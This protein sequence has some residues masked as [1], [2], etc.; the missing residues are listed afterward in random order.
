M[1]GQI[2]TNSTFGSTNF[3]GGISCILSANPEAGFSVASYNGNNTIGHGLG[4]IPEVIIGKLRTSSNWTTY[5]N[6]VDGSSDY[7]LLNST[8][9]GAT[10][11]GTYTSTVG[12]VQNSGNGMLYAFVSIP[13]YSKMGS[14]TGNGNAS[15]PF[16]NTGFKPAFTLIKSTASSSYWWEILDNK[17]SP[18]NALDKTL[19]ANVSDGEYSGSGY[20]KDFLSN[21]FKIRNGS[22]ATNSN[23][24]TYLYM[25]FAEAPFKTANAR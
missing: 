7:M 13:G 6:V 18:S 10:G 4:K 23:G 8:Q 14:Y 17:R 25:A 12:S 16:V 5:Y 3:D 15:G 1:G 24:G 21:G 19:Y 2:N 9:A 11:G 22:G 20:A